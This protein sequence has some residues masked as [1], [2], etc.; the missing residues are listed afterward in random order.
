MNRRQKLKTVEQTLKVLTEGKEEILLENP[1]IASLLR[2]GLTK[3]LFGDTVDKVVGKIKSSKDDTESASD[4]LKKAGLDVKADDE[5]I[6]DYLEDDKLSDEELENLGV[7]DEDISE[8]VSEEDFSFYTRILK[9]LGVP[10][11][12]S[13]Y[14]FLYGIAQ[15][16][17]TKAKYNPFATTMKMPGSKLFGTNVAGVQSYSDEKEG[18]KA[19]VDTMKLK[20]YKSIVDA[21]KQND[22]SDW[23]S[24]LENVA[25]K[26]VASPWGTKTLMPN[27]HGY[28]SGNEP[29]PKAISRS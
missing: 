11:S 4:I 24:E 14:F 8:Y 16:E 9:G 22:G 12:K 18:I 29:K 17:V 5:E 6:E 2:M 3:Y 20:Y 19:T 7:E 25:E 27:I 10:L 15:S 23:E 13:N 28:I 1:L 26:W 21:M